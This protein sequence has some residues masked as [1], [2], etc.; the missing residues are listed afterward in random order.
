[1]EPERVGEEESGPST[2]ARRRPAPDTR[3]ASH[4]LGGGGGGGGGGEA[5]PDGDGR[6]SPPAAGDSMGGRTRER[7]EEEGRS[8][9]KM[10]TKMETRKL[11]GPA[12]SGRTFGVWQV[13]AVRFKN[14]PV[15][16]LPS[17]FAV[18]AGLSGDCHVL[19]VFFLESTCQWA[20]FVRESAA[21]RNA[22]GYRCSN[23]CA[24]RDD[25]GRSYTMKMLEFIKVYMS[26]F[27]FHILVH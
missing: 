8:G 20:C 3:P 22:C 17:F 16:G 9:G 19:N 18:A 14:V 5:P 2:E 15:L 12:V 26:R 24:I 7:A 23:A 21:Y 11:T 4:P 27:F 13:W 6:G 10:G 1:V 25:A